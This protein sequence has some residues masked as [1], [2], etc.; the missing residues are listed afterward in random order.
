MRESV[1]GFLNILVLLSNAGFEATSLM[2]F[3]D[4]VCPIQV[5]FETVE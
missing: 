1:T 4:F 2:S 5:Q 3:H